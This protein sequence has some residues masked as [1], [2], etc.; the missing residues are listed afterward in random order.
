VSPHAP[1]PPADAQRKAMLYMAGFAL[2]WASVE[3]IGAGLLGRYSAY[4]VVFTRYAT[5]LIVMLLVWGLRKGA[6]M[7]RTARP[8]YQWARS[9][10][11]FGMPVSFVMA[12]EHGI[13]PHT[14]MS[15]FWLS[16]CLILVLSALVQR[17]R[18]SWASWL[19]TLAAL[20]GTQL[21][22]GVPPALPAWWLAV[23]PAGMAA[24]FALYVVMTRSLRSEPTRVNLF[25]TA[26]GVAVV[27]LPIA[28]MRWVTPTPRD[29]FLM[30]AIG[31]VGLLSLL[32]LDLATALAPAPLSAPVL[33]LQLPAFLL[34][35][36][37]LHHAPVT[38]RLVVG[39]AL[40]AGSCAYAWW[41]SALPRDAVT[42]DV[43]SSA[44]EPS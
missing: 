39:S 3:Q 6:P 25:Y 15:M 29:L 23:F 14:L 36:V 27:M 8:R 19:I 9:M 12:F 5:H 30:I 16:P 33:H 31:V 35:D 21:L 18:A 11:M 28:C 4:Q 1:H 44:G 34:L 32:C 17:E 26:F 37:A 42:A 20:L 2:G 40:V 43:R 10:L 41:R 7:W 24:T 22:L 13:S 38:R